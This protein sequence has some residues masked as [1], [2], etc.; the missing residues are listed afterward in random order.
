M[1]TWW[2]NLSIREKQTVSLGAVSITAFL[3]YA[4]LFA[5]LANSVDALRKKIH[6]NQTLLAWM[7]ESNQR[8]ATLEKTQTISAPKSSA[9]LLSL[10]QTDINS[11][12]FGKSV[13]ALQ[14]ADNDSI[15]LRLQKIS[16]DA[17]T[18]WLIAICQQHNLLITQM[19]AQPSGTPG[20]VDIDIKLQS[21]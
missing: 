5:P 18:K 3:V 8:I 13:T 4:I 12:P 10:I 6:T 9:S 7:Q 1:K 17:F 21:S 19:T 14:Q 16:F 20:I 11:Q 2:L 15:Q